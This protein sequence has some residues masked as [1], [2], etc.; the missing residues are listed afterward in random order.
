MPTSGITTTVEVSTDDSTYYDVDGTDTV[1]EDR[2]RM[3]LMSTDFAQSGVAENSFAGLS[4]GNFQ[5]SGAWEGS[6]TNGQVAVRTAQSDGS[7]LYVRV[8]YDGTIG[9]K[10]ACKVF[11]CQKN[12]TVDGRVEFSWTGD[13]IE[14]PTD[15]T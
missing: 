15:V 4:S 5:A 12:S 11:S 10:A 14:I 3:K 1:S 9:S 8:L 2:T 13:F 6:D 7:T